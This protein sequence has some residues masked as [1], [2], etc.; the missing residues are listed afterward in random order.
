VRVLVTGASGFVGS[1]VCRLL[2][3][4]QHDVITLRDGGRA[5][6]VELSEAGV[7]LESVGACPPDA[8]VHLAAR[9]RAAPGDPWRDVYANNVTATYGLLAAVRAEAPR[10]RILLASSSAVYRAVPRGRNPVTEDERLRP[11]SLYGASK[12]ACEAL[13]W[14]HA[15]AGPGVVICRP[16]NLVGPGGEDRSAL[17]QWARQVASI[18][19]GLA[20]G[21]VRCGPLG[22]FR[23]LTDVRDAARAYVSLVEAQEPPDV[24]NICSGAAHSGEEVMSLLLEEADVQAQID[25]APGATDDLEY[26]CGDN[27]RI[28]RS[29]G[30]C[31]E[32]P[33]RQ[34]VRDVLAEWLAW[35]RAEGRDRGATGGEGHGDGK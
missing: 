10:A 35:D 29:V 13:A 1:H 8:E 3:A 27:A 31:P 23:D 25:S 19:R 17:A 11:V 18:K 34:S 7:V 30:W 24:V 2:R 20:P 16:F 15:A 22:T 32:I 14:T 21:V 5:R 6:G 26:Q 12:V 4:R 28:V 9:I 33:L